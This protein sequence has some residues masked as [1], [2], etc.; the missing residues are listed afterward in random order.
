MR[1]FAKK[2]R[3]V[4]KKLYVNK[5][6]IPG[7]GLGLFAGEDIKAGDRISRY[8]GEVNGDNPDSSYLLDLE[9]GR[10]VDAKMA[11]DCPARYAN[12]A[13]DDFANN[14]EFILTGSVYAYIFSTR[15]ISKGEE[16]FVSY[17]EEYWEFH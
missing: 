7:A 4:C 17:G 11:T 2:P 15:D 14:A 8:W 1:R 12:D 3:W 16:I 6:T 5:S 10:Y 13:R 9:D